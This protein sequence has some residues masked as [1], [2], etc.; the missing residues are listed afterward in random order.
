VQ[1]HRSEGVANRTG[2]ES[3]V[4][5]PRGR[6]EALTGECI[7]QPLSREKEAVPGA[8][9]LAW[10]EGNMGGCVIASIRPIRRGRRPWHVQTLF[11]REPGELV[12]GQGGVVPSL[13]RVGKARS[14][15][16]R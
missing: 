7:G 11:E 13:V 15:S 10:A 8:D 12:I 2:P 4:D 1:V 3:C 14:R 16:R 9:A 6:G 5:D